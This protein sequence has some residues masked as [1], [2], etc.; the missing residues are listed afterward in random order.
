MTDHRGHHLGRDAV[1]AV[2]WGDPPPGVA[3]ERH[4]PLDVEHVHH[5]HGLARGQEG[6]P[7][8]LRAAGLTGFGRGEEPVEG[9]GVGLSRRVDVD[10]ALEV[11]AGAGKEVG[12]GGAVTGRERPQDQA[13]GDDCAGCE[14][15]DRRAGR[16]RA[17]GSWVG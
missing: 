16:S 6:G 11:V 3:G 1:A 10:A 17:E 2:E 15:L 5:P 8:P 12:E 9:G 7:A 14:R 4:A 13:W